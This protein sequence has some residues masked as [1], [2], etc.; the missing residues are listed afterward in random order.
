[1]EA[2]LFYGPYYGEIAWNGLE[3]YQPKRSGAR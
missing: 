3:I 1:M 2:Y